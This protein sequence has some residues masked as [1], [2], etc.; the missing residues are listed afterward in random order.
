MG[1]TKTFYL[2]NGKKFTS[3]KGLAKELRGITHDTFKHHVNK[4]KNDFS[5]WIKHS[6]EKDD[7]A[8]KIEKRLDK[9]EIELEILRHLVHEEDTPKKKANTTKKAVKKTNPAPKKPVKKTATKTTTKKV[10]PKKKATKT[11]TKKAKK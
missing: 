6:L 1:H 4:E 5:N 3:L 9:I 8:I 11:T 7:L 10:A 2:N